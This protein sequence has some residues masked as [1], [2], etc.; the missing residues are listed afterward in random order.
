[1]HLR[2]FVAIYKS[3]I[4][5]VTTFFLLKLEQYAI[6]EPISGRVDKASAS[7]M[8]DSGSIPVWVKPMTIKIGIHGSQA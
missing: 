7:E 1:M 2:Y 5:H 8:V 4:V 6:F 3:F